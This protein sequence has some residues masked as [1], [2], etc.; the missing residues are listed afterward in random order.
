M[1][2]RDDGAEELGKLLVTM[3]K[4]EKLKFDEEA[5]NE[6]V[7]T[8][9]DQ[10]D[11]DNDGQVDFDEFVEYY[12]SL[13]DRLNTGEVQALKEEQKKVEVKHSKQDDEILRRAAPAGAAVQP[14]IATTPGQATVHQAVRSERGAVGC[15]IPE[16]ACGR[17]T[18]G[19]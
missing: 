5:V 14:G 9:F 4:N 8:E 12:N 1:P 2:I 11:T 3:L 18:E 15:G 7:K 17:P 16:G 6:F 10:A 13:M 19:W